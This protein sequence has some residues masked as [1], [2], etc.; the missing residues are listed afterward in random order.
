MKDVA[1]VVWVTGIAVRAVEVDVART[2]TTD[3]VKVVVVVEDLM[4]RHLHCSVSWEAGMPAATHA[5]CCATARFFSGIGCSVTVTV[6][7][8]TAVTVVV[9]TIV[10]RVGTV[11]TLIVV[12]VAVAVRAT[13]VVKVDGIV[14]ASVV[15]VVVVDATAVTVTVS[16]P[17]PR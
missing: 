3:G 14:V 15:V 13:S 12:V 6:V 9:T 5:G 16:L 11:A 1:N 10:V 8:P 2:T 7:C 4:L 17:I